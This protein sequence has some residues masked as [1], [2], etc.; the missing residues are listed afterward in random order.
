MPSHGGRWKHRFLR[1]LAKS[2]GSSHTWAL[3]MALSLGH[4]ASLRPR[5]PVFKDSLCLQSRRP[6]QRQ[7]RKQRWHS[8]QQETKSRRQ[9][10]TSQC[11]MSRSQEEQRP[12]DS[13]KCIETKATGSGRAETS[14]VWG[15]TGR[16]CGEGL[17]TRHGK[18][19][20]GKRR[21]LV[22][23]MRKVQHPNK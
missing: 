17:T 9:T 18:M 11:T 4:Q 7:Q 14:A 13:L 5:V 3:L 19:S 22:W 15:S 20:G 21:K 10:V 8:R 12:T 1:S 16:S 2:A 6:K 23:Q